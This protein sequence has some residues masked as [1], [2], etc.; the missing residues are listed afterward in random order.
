MRKNIRLMM[1]K[2]AVYILMYE[3]KGGRQQLYK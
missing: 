3:E 1:K 2:T